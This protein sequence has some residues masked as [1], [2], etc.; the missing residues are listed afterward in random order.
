VLSM[1]ATQTGR[2]IGSVEGR[3]E[4]RQKVSACITSVTSKPAFNHFRV[5]NTEDLVH[6]MQLSIEEEKCNMRNIEIR[7]TN[8]TKEVEDVVVHDLHKPESNAILEE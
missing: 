6:V 7:K 1:L 5:K 3:E 2:Y 8:Q 4:S